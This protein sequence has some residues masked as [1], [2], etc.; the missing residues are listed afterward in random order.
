MRTLST[1]ELS[2]VAGAGGK[3]YTPPVCQPEPDCSTGK[4]K[5]P[6]NG[7]GNG[8]FDGVPGHSNHTDYDR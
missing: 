2:L 4:K 8:A 3:C 1:Q 7:F 6:N 5:H